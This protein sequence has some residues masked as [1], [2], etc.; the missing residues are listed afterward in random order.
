MTIEE[1]FW[2]KVDNAGP[3]PIGRPDLGRCWLW[4][5]T[6]YKTG[7]GGFNP[8]GPRPVYAHRWSYEFL[9]GPISSGLVIDHLC[10]TR[11]CV[12]PLHLEPVTN[13]I[14]VLR[15]LK[16]MQTHCVHGHLFN[17]AN[18]GRNKYGHRRCRVCAHL[19][20]SNRARERKR[21]R[22]I[23]RAALAASQTAGHA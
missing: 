10:R 6:K 8:A 4:T 21:Q 12:H 9:I 1:R 13:A 15:G 2:A 20:S 11:A 18:T 16:G 3:L 14:N 7:Y 23:R 5:A 22:H 17:E 19:Y